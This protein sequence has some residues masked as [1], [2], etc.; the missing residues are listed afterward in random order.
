MIIHQTNVGHIPG[1]QSLVCSVL[2][3]RKD[4][5]FH[6]GASEL[7]RFGSS[8]I[9]PVTSDLYKLVGGIP[10]F[11]LTDNQMLAQATSSWEFSSVG[12]QRWFSDKIRGDEKRSDS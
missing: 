1:L 8:L 12:L 6:R 7:S 5:S 10:M 11:P 2:W 4:I 9:S 3:R